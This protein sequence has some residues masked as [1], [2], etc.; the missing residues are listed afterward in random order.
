MTL[1]QALFI[2]DA[3][4]GLLLVGVLVWILASRRSLTT[5]RGAQN[6][7]PAPSDEVL[8][9]RRLERV[10]GAAL[11]FVVT[12]A[13]G[14]SLY[15][16]FEPTRQAAAD[17]GFDE[18]SVE[19]GAV[20]FASKGMKS[21][22]ST[23]SLQ[24]ANCHGADA[25]GGTAPFTIKSE[26]KS[27][28]KP[29]DTREVCLPKAVTWKAPA[30]NTVFYRFPRPKNGCTGL[31]KIDPTNQDCYTQVTDIITFGRPGTPMPAW[32]VSSGKGVLNEQGISDL[33]NYLESIQVSPAKARA[34]V[35]ADGKALQKDAAS[36]VCTAKLNFAKANAVW[37]FFAP[38]DPRAPAGAKASRGALCDADAKTA[39]KT[40]GDDLKGKQRQTLYEDMALA[41]RAGDTPT[42]VEAVARTAEA[43]KNS[44]A[45][46]AKVG[47]AGQGELL[48]LTQC[49]RCHT[50]GWSYVDP[51]NP[52][53]PLPA[54]DGS[55]AFGPNLTNGST[56]RQFPKVS[57]QV[58]FITNGSVFQQGY[59]V[60]GVGT[61][62]MPGFGDR[63]VGSPNYHPGMLTKKQIEAIVAFER[64]L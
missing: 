30:L 29:N 57:D 2:V 5:E 49:A 32:G 33:V 54:P 16:L 36:A 3:V 4:V 60:R 58:E 38:D 10:L 56:K 28:V 61:G 63:N 31:Q 18:R 39:A 1:R 37:A 62:R 34:Q 6:V 64:S 41:I 47:S 46:E 8:E 26:N 25:G 55:G 17:K 20:L 50:K 53:T 15:W 23:R 42:A 11:V 44:E 12:I 19:R 9:T 13:A 14:L 24:C 21:Y 7:T 48:F 43:V 35:A 59:G 51:S 27:C 52:D 40:F 45:F 22:D